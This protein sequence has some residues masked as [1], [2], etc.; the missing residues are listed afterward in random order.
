MSLEVGLVGELVAIE[1]GSADDV[2]QHVAHVG[3][4]L[5]LGDAAILHASDD[6]VDFGLVA[7]LHEVVSGISGFHGAGLGTPVGHHDSVKS[8]LVAEDSC[9]KVTALLC[10]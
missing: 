2:L 5:L 10:E 9:Q 1:L 7:R 8:P 4:Q 6:A 3:V